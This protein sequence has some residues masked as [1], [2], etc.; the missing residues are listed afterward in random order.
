MQ[1]DQPNWLAYA[2]QIA[3]VD[4]KAAAFVANKMRQRSYNDWEGV[5]VAVAHNQLAGFCTIVKEDIVLF[6]SPFYC[7]RVCCSQLSRQ[8]S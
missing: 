3:S 8:S 5:F 4:W 2:G 7:D 6:K 1:K